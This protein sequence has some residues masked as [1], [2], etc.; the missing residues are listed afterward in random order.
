MNEENVIT[1]ELNT[2]YSSSAK[3]D[4]RMWRYSIC[5]L[6]VLNPDYSK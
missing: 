3:E 5:L 4:F 2:V 6:T 1:E